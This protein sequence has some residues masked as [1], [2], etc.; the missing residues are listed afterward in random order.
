MSGTM[1][2]Y[3]ARR[4]KEYESIYF[5][6]DPVRQKEQI[7]IQSAL[8]ESL[9][10]KHVLEI[11]CGTG[12]WTKF[13]SESAGD[14]VATDFNQEVIEIA[15]QKRY[16]CP[17]SFQR[18]DA[19]NLPFK[20]ATFT[21]G[22][23]NFWFSHVPK[24]KIA[25]FL[26]LFHRTLQPGSRVFMADNVNVPGLGGELIAKPGDENT[27]KLRTL[28]DGAQQEILKNYFTPEELVSIFSAYDSSFSLAEVS[29]GE[30]FWRL[31][32]RV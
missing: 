32:Y 11:A 19:Y 22:M 10:E 6:D 23:A 25:E 27:Y 28:A 2:A 21:G 5:R 1:E 13:L 31:T 14:I 29:Q 17:V 26:T 18:A 8:Q 16:A 12:Y 9:Q 30:C 4:A 3:Y 24:A 15:Q 7:E 20:P